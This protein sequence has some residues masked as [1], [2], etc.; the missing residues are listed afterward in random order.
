M[1]ED[2]LDSIEQ[3]YVQ[4]EEMMG[5]QDV[6]TDPRRL[7]ELGRERAELGDLVEIYRKYRDTNQQLI[8]TETMLSNDG[9]DPEMAELV[10]SEID[11]LQA[12]RDRQMAEI[13][14]LLLPK[15]PAS[16]T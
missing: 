12:Q 8:E 15:D 14:R 13:K 11:T 6:V 3:H 5:H 4:L 10:R 2:K 7:M 9:L 1:L 16:T